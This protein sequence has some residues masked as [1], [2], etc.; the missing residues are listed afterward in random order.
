VEKGILD[1]GSTSIYLEI[2]NGK[3]AGGYFEEGRKAN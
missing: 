2:Q 1:V 3:V